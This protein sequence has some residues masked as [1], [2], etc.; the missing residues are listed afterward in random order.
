MVPVAP[1]LVDGAGLVLAGVLPVA[2]RS[3]S[4]AP[5]SILGRVCQVNTQLAAGAGP[6]LVEWFQWNHFKLAGAEVSS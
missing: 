5:R 4:T 1:Q 6:F 2:Q 3:S